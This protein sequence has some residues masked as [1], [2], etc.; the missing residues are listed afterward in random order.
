MLRKILKIKDRVSNIANRI[1]KKYSS[2]KSSSWKVQSKFF[3]ENISTLASEE[4]ICVQLEAWKEFNN[5][6]NPWRR[7]NCRS[8]AKFTRGRPEAFRGS[9]KGYHSSISN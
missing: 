9:I 5:D 8:R 1:N 6:N 3:A 4:I 2:Y 7:R